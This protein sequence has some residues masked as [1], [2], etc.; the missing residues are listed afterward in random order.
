M[1]TDVFMLGQSNQHGSRIF[2]QDRA[3]ARMAEASIAAVWALLPER[4]ILRHLRTHPHLSMCDFFMWGHLF[5]ENVYKEKPYTLVNNK[6][7]NY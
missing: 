5:K 7:P 2:L 6:K 1:T 4:V 3:T